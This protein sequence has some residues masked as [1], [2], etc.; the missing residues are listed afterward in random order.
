MFLAILAV[1]V[2][3]A[4]A[5]PSSW[6]AGR[7]T[8]VRAVTLGVKFCWILADPTTDHGTLA[9]LAFLPDG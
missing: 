2:V 4:S 3:L 5:E 1:L 7:A 6:F 9:L 8:W